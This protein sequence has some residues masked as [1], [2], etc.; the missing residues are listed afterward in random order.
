[1]LRFLSLLWILFFSGFSYGSSCSLIVEQT[2]SFKGVEYS[3]LSNDR[4]DTAKLMNENSVAIGMYANGH[5]MIYFR[6]YRIDSSGSAGLDVSSFLTKASSFAGDVL[7]IVRDVPSEV[8]DALNQLINQFE[9][10][11]ERSCIG[12]TCTHLIDSNLPILNKKVLTPG[13]LLNHLLEFKKTSDLNV[14]IYTL[15]N[16]NLKRIKTIFGLR[17]VGVS[18]A[19]AVSGFIIGAPFVVVLREIVP[20]LF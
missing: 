16:R 18:G 15:N 14:D 10:I 8:V 9:S 17:T 20:L 3:I 6:G 19:L 1:M 2:G 4:V 5:S 7:V 12:T 11:T 13:S